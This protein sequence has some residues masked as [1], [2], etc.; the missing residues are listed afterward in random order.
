MA[1]PFATTRQAS[2]IVNGPQDLYNQWFNDWQNRKNAEQA[3]AAPA[4][5]LSNFVAPLADN[6]VTS[7]MASP[8]YAKAQSNLASAIA[9]PDTSGYVASA[10]APP[11]SNA[12]GN[13]DG[14]WGSILG[15]AYATAHGGATTDGFTGDWAQQTAQD[16]LGADGYAKLMNFQ[17]TD[18]YTPNLSGF[19][20][21]KKA[22]DAAFANQWQNQ[23]SLQNAYSAQLGG[24]VPGGILADQSAFAG[25]P[26]APGANGSALPTMPWE[27]P[28]YGGGLGG[29]GGYNPN[30]WSTA[31]AAPAGGGGNPWGGPFSNKNPFSPGS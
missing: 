25:T 10:A 8:D 19:D 18:G 15:D 28:G 14:T 3:K 30:P 2:Q 16:A 21:E 5:S 12:H 7:F 6:Y 26:N 1:D 31:G 17:P 29:L 4:Q 22:S 24:G 20:A 13:L 11:I 9:N 27:T 23:Q